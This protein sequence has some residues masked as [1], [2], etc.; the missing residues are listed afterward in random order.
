MDDAS[1]SL[2]SSHPVLETL[3]VAKGL[4]WALALVPLLRRIPAADVARA[5]DYL[6]KGLA[7]GAVLTAVVV[8]IERHRFVGLA[9]FDGIFRVTGNFSAMNN[10]GAYIEA[11]L[12]LAI[13]A[14]IIWTLQQ[15]RLLTRLLGASAVAL[16]TYA[17]FV[18]FSRGGYGGLAVGLLVLLIGTF[19]AKGHQAK[20]YRLGVA[21]LGVVAALAATPILLG[22]FAQGRLAQIERDL[23]FRLGHWHHAIGL[24]DEGFTSK[25]FGMGFGTY[26]STYLWRSDRTP[27]PGTFR[28]ESDGNL[29]YLRLGTGDAYY[30]DQIPGLKPGQR[31]QVDARVRFEDGQDGLQLALCEKALLYSF[32]CNWFEL[33]GDAS[34]A[35][36]TWQMLTTSVDTQGLGETGRWPGPTLKLS[37]V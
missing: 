18:T 1:L 35:P 9:D 26:P 24:M 7:I 31:Y 28:V 29:H 34:A 32:S 14:L 30:L 33:K 17:M 23:E 2:A 16:A 12:A 37:L 21:A 6:V 10:G 8:A 13:P 25:L 4:F 27:L 22:E 20:R 11:Y 3:I 36:G 5:R 19:F 15:R